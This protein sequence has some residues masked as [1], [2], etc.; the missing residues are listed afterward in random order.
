MLLLP[1]V[2]SELACAVTPDPRVLSLVPPG[3]QIV[4]GM[5]AP[6]GQG[7]P[8]SFLL[9]TRNNHADLEEF[10]A[11]SGADSSRIIHQ[12]IFVAGGGGQDNAGEHSLLV[13]GH[14]DQ[15]RLYQ[16]AVENGAIPSEYNG[17]RIVALRPFDRDH[18]IDRDLRWFAVLGSTVAVLGTKFSVQ[19]EIGRQQSGIAADPSFVQKLRRLHREDATWCIMSHLVLS[20]E[21]RHSFDSLNPKLA[22]LVE[23]KDAF[24]FGI[25]YGARVEFEYEITSAHGNSAETISNTI[26]R[27]LNGE[28]GIE[29]SL[30]PDPH[31]TAGRASTRASVKLSRARWEAWVAEVSA[32]KRVSAAK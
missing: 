3:A 12:V 1:V 10:F 14:F 5:N 23:E 9:L 17:I 25:H 11:L 31:M 27:S 20:E 15:Q 19:Q 16:S 2:W 21:M 24:Q 13:S 7:Q 6:T 26:S 22:E 30:L 18:G 8:D 28:T 29:S 4:A 32:Q